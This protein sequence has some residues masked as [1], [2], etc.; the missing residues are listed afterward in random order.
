MNE[1]AMMALTRAW[2]T[3]IGTQVQTMDCS[4]PRRQR[5]RLRLTDARQ[6][7]ATVLRTAGE[8]LLTLAAR[9]AH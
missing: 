2:A 9:L 6:A 4:T 1:M 7:V 5:K 3:G 8:A